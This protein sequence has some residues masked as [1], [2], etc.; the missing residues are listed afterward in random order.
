[1]CCS[2]RFFLW[3]IRLLPSVRCCV[4]RCQS[5]HRSTS[6]MAPSQSHW[7]FWTGNT[8]QRER[9][10]ERE[11]E[12]H[13]H[14]HTHT[15]IHTPP[16]VLPAT[17]TQCQRR[18]ECSGQDS[19][20]LPGISP[21]TPLK[22]ADRTVSDTEGEKEREER[23]REKREESW[24]NEARPHLFRFLFYFFSRSVAGGQRGWWWRANSALLFARCCSSLTWDQLNMVGS[25]FI[26]C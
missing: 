6:V 17:H 19:A 24:E 16:S 23:K 9:E 2:C 15:H 26:V 21:T 13:T 7:L 22:C 1:M 11:R 25:V 3:P 10:I 18:R 20:Q 12:T 14:T 5:L 4:G 8:W